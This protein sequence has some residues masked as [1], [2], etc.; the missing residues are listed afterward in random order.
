MKRALVKILVIT[1]FML[2]ASFQAFAEDALVTFTKGKVE[3]NRDGAWVALNVGDSVKETEIVNT[4]FQSEAKLKYKGSV[5]TL[6]ALTRVTLRQ[7]SSTESKDKVDVYLNTGAVR[8]KVT[9][10]ANTRVSYKVT[11]PVSVASVRGTTIVSFGSGENECLSGAMVVYPNNEA[12][13]RQR[14]SDDSKEG[15]NGKATSNTAAEDIDDKAPAGAVV[16]GAGQKAEITDDGDVFKTHSENVDNTNLMT[17]SESDL[18]DS[19]GTSNFES[20][21]LKSS[22]GSIKFILEFE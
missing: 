14:K 3:V 7:L 5:M 1:L 4:G 17:L 15:S 21:S 18:Y 20:D 13:T 16:V 19:E 22:V 9:H 10:T 6:A 2:S 12:N 8:S 11:G